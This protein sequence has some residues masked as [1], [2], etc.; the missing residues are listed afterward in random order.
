MVPRCLSL[1][2]LLEEFFE[3]E[4]LS[5]YYLCG[6]CNKSSKKSTKTLQI[7]RAPRFLI[8]HLKRSQF[9]KKNNDP[10]KLPETLSMKSFM[11]MSS[12]LV[13]T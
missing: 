6:N 12:T 5:D 2:D 13:S 4:K 7:W 10:I 9:T 1:E 11:T 8:I 3:P